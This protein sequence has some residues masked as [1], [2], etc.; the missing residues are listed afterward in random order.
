VLSRSASIGATRDAL[1]AGEIAAAIVMPVPR[2]SDTTTVR[3]AMTSAVGGSL[4][5]IAATSAFSPIAS[6]TPTPTPTID[7]TSPTTAASTKTDVITC[8]RRAPSARNSA[9][10]LLRWAT[11]MLKV[12]KMM[13]APTNRATN[14][15]TRS[16]VRRNP[17]PLLTWSCCSLAA[18]VPVLASKRAGRTPVIR[19]A[20]SSGLT[21]PS[22]FT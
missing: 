3:D 9:N 8:R 13:N 18:V 17:R 4:R 11:T 6:T 5:P 21:D 2:S 14:P 15:N 16:P 7:A 1:R 22:P 10:S 20:S 12:L 19:V